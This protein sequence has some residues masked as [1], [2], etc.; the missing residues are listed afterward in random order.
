SA[1]EN[2]CV[3]LLSG[4]GAARQPINTANGS[5]STAA[6]AL[7]NA[8]S[9]R[10]L[11]VCRYELKDRLPDG[12]TGHSVVQ[13]SRAFRRN[14]AGHGRDRMR[15][16]YSFRLLAKGYSQRKQ[17]NARVVVIVSYLEKHKSSI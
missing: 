5:K 4:P 12:L 6:A 11:A 10:K 13:D 15:R 8:R 1:I 14:Q 2:G 17:I 9:R 3:R 7:K 16:T